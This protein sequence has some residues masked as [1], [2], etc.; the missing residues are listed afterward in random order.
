MY[1][2]MLAFW[3]QVLFRLTNLRSHHY[4]ALTLGILA[5]G[6]DA[7]N[8]GNHGELFWLTRFEEFSNT[9]QTTSDV[10]GLGGFARDIGENVTGHNLGVFLNQD[11]SANR[12]HT[13]LR[14]FVALVFD[15]DARTLVS[16]LGF[17]NNLTGKTRNIVNL[18]LD[19]KTFDH[20][21][22]ANLTGSFRKNRHGEGVPF[23]NNQPF[24]YSITLTDHQAS[25][26]N[27]TVTLTFTASL[28]D[29]SNLSIT[30]H[31]YEATF[32]IR[33]CRQVDKLECTFCTRLKCSLLC[34]T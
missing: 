2:D 16:R 17:D 30:V 23:R 14:G 28:I 31:N 9:R 10:L 5:E 25:T 33:G 8:L 21:A 3:N 4:L 20:V 26:V 18:L 15:R 24:G 1:A 34:L 13:T 19:S 27:D 32:A 6:N 29:H 11:I 7:V 12:H 22:E